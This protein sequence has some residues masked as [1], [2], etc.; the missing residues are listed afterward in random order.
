MYVSIHLTNRYAR[1]WAEKM[2]EKHKQD[3]SLLSIETDTDQIKIHLPPGHAQV[4][5]KAWPDLGISDT[6]RTA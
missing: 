4:I 2:G 1:V 3:W 6:E 5:A